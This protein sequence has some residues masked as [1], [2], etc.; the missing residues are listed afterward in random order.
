MIGDFIKKASDRVR[1]IVD[2]A[3]W[4]FQSDHI[5]K[6]DQIMSLERPEIRRVIIRN[7]STLEELLRA[8]GKTQ[9]L[10]SSGGNQP[11]DQNQLG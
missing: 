10:T 1:Y 4:G 7:R 9:P 11:G 6:F 2:Y 8:T 3:V 5:R